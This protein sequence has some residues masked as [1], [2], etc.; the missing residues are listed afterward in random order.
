MRATHLNI[1]LLLLLLLLGRRPES[2]FIHLK[3]SINPSVVFLSS[4][5]WKRESLPCNN[6]SSLTVSLLLLQHFFGR[7]KEKKQWPLAISFS[8]R[9]AEVTSNSFPPKSKWKSA[10][11]PPGLPASLL[12]LVNIAGES[13]DHFSV[14]FY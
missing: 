9:H 5:L 13:E 3:A 14:G 1:E 2:K 12:Y 11:P 7:K 8:L 6:D 10:C 4:S